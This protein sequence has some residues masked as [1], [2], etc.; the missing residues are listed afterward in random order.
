VSN[1]LADQ[2]Y[3]WNNEPRQANTINVS[4][5][6]ARSAQNVPLMVRTLQTVVE[7]YDSSYPVSTPSGEFNILRSSILQIR[8]AGGDW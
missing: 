4:V 3:V 6:G 7:H 5:N 8:G 2:V 1:D